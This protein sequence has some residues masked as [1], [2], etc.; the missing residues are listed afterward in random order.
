M[1]R[2]R[3]A[4]AG[5]APRGRC[6]RSPR[7]GG[8]DA[9]APGPPDSDEA[10]ESEESLQAE[11][12]QALRLLEQVLQRD[13]AASSNEEDEEEL[14]ADPRSR[15]A[16]E[17]PQSRKVFVGG[18]PWAADPNEVEAHFEKCGDI[19]SFNMPVNKKTNAPMGIAFIIFS[20][21]EGV[22]RALECNGTQYG[23]QRLRVA[24]AELDT[25]RGGDRSQAHAA[26]GRGGRGQFPGRGPGRAGPRGG[27]GGRGEFPGRGWRG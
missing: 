20:S 2:R 25:P 13:A 18:L 11:R 24:V 19:D 10:P 4:P 6:G 27:R 9:A 16:A 1:K 17:G 26:P 7:A 3:G 8:E 15:K 5:A 22:A 12:A 21:A 23:G 14:A